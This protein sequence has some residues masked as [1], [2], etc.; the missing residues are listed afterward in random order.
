[1]KQGAAAVV[2]G[3][4]VAMIA[5]AP[6]SAQTLSIDLH[7][8]R[9]SEQ[10]TALG[11]IGGISVVVT[12]ARLWSRSVPALHG[13]MTAVTALRLIATRCGGEVEAIEQRR[14][15][16]WGGVL[17]REQRQHLADPG[18]RIH[19]AGAGPAGLRHHADSLRE[20]SVVAAGVSAE[21]PHGP[22]VGSPQAAADLHRGGLASPV[23][24][25][26][27]RHSTRFGHK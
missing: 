25:E 14:D 8:G 6:A 15:R 12:D 19:P 23:A 7:A 21:H 18:R 26:E 11:R 22:G 20:R 13:R 5:A 16:Q 4:P 9:V 10:V 3:L 2:I 17:R 24:P 1:V 27:S